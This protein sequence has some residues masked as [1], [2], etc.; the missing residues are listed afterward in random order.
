MPSLWQ[1]TKLFINVTIFNRCIFIT[2][3]ID[4]WNCILPKYLH[5]QSPPAPIAISW[6]AEKNISC[7]TEIIL[8]SDIPENEIQWQKIICCLSFIVITCITRTSNP[9]INRNT[10]TFTETILNVILHNIDWMCGTF[11]LYIHILSKNKIQ[12]KF[13][14]CSPIVRWVLNISYNPL[15]TWFQ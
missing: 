6:T 4:G 15:R 13:L 14:H 8:N 12:R 7:E 9:I 5:M 1:M 11:L 2:V 3:I 10:L